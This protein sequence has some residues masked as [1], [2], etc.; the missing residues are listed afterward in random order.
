MSTVRIRDVEPADAD[1]I[2]AVYAHHVENGTATYDLEPPSI[3][4]TRAKIERIVGRGWPFLVA[5][6][7][8]EVAGYA[9]VEQF[10]ERAAY[11]FACEDS[12]YVGPDR[13]GRGIGKAL[14]HA[15]CARAEAF[16]F[17]QMLAVIGGAEPA[18]IALHRGCGFEQ[19][20]CLD[21]AGWKHERWLDTVYMQRALGPGSSEPPSTFPS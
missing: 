18:S 14:L 12:I 4:S 10:R 15:L 16:G 21:A 6:I 3:E 20:G 8:G 9:Y 1:A 7:H 17:R 5:T 13:L 19:V 11:R 2:A